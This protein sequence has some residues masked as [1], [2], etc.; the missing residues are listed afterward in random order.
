METLFGKQWVAVARFNRIERRHIHAGLSIKVPKQIDDVEY[1]SPLPLLYLAAE[2]DSRFIL[3]N[4]SEHFLG[5]YEYDI[6]SFAV[7]IASGNGHDETP[8]GEFRLTAAKRLFEWILGGEVGHDRVIAIAEWVTGLHPWQGAEAAL[9][10]K[11]QGCSGTTCKLFRCV[12][13]EGGGL[14]DS[15]DIRADHRPGR[16]VQDRP[17]VSAGTQAKHRPGESSGLWDLP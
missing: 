9:S 4:L 12:S 1:F 7:P 17:H 15:D 16:A 2:E 6:L 13:R 5:A 8:T 3:I 10:Q 14:D 11:Q